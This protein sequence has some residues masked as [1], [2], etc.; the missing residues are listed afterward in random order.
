MS[1][2]SVDGLDMA[3]CE[4]KQD[5]QNNWHYNILVTDNKAYS[6]EWQEK[7]KNIMHTNSLQLV[8]ADFELGRLYGSWVNEFMI[9]NKLNPDAIASHGHTVFHQPEKGITWQIGQAFE[10]QKATNTPVINDFRKL[11]LVLGGQGAPLV[12]A[13]D[14]LLFGN[15][16]I[17]LNLGGIANLSAEY[18][19]NRIAYDICPCNLALN[20]LAGQKNLTYDDKGQLAR[21]GKYQEE[22]I[23]QLNQLSY[24]KLPYPKSLGLEWL[25][26]NIFPL[27]AA[28]DYNVDDLLHTFTHHIAFQIA[29][30][31]QKHVPDGAS[32]ML[33]TGGGAFNDFLIE[34]IRHYTST[35]TQIEVPTHQ[36]IEYK[37]ALVFAFL[38]ALRLSG[39]INTYKSVTGAQSDSCGGV[40][41]NNHFLSS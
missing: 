26:D 35:N 24:Y 25:E 17:C 8:E 41:H 12:P 37:E 27:L 14:R 11:D 20:F 23:Q 38:A 10:I 32:Q 3:F 19:G 29:K 6:A 34:L 7:L 28:S 13:G 9:K 40:I 30:A 18:Q 4:F 21:Q 16:D 31:A 33:I 36:L 2:T 15:F 22:L 1:G 39:Q 5:E